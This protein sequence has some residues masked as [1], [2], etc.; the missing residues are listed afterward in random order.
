MIKVKNLE[1]LDCLD[2]PNLITSPNVDEKGRVKAE[3]DSK[4]EG[5]QLAIAGFE[6]GERGP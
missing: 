5:A 6:D 1:F 3:K 2:E 4:C